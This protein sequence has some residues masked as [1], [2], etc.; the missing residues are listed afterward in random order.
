MWNSEKS[1]GLSKA[2][3]WIFLG[4]LVILL[5]S[6][7]TVVSY[8]IEFSRADLSTVKALFVWTI[9]I[10]SIPAMVLL[11]SLLKLIRRIECGDVFTHENVKLL[12][13]ISWSCFSGTLVACTS[14][15]Y[16]APWIFIAI[17]S[18]F[19][20]LVVRIIKNAFSQAV[21]L[22]EEVDYTI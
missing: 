15:F 21:A 7:S 10:G 17:A 2:F 14:M 3:I 22:K 8:F 1:I 11:V 6:A 12:R 9:Y 13:H 16:Y 4:L 5:F 19:M 18:A 20:G